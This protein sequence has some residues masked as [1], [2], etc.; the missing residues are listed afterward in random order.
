MKPTPHFFLFLLLS[1][2]FLFLSGFLAPLRAQPIGEYLGDERVFYAETKQVNQ[3]FRRFNCE[4]SPLGKRYYPGDSLYHDR[5]LR[6]EYLN[7]LF[8]HSNAALDAGLRNRFIRKVTRMTDPQYLEFHGGEWFAEVNTTFGY[9]GERRPLTFYMQLEKDTIGSKWVFTNVYFKPFAEVF[10]E[11]GQGTPPDF[12]HPLSHELDFMN[13]I[14]VF[15]DDNNPEKYIQQGHSPDF[16]TLFLYEYRKGN[17]AFHTVNKVK[18]HFFQVDDW[19]FE[20]SQVNREGENR[21]WLITQ[22][23][24]IPAGKKDILLKYIYQQ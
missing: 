10:R 21:G 12:L 9:K 11:N 15:R 16:L 2:G 4:E 23:T 8:D 14:K 18:F 5:T 19:Y 3:F 20:L 13:L 17:L 24:E 6:K 1:F 22:M 7:L